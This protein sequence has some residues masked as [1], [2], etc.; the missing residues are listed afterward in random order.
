MTTDD[1]R[2]YSQLEIAD[3]LFIGMMHDNKKDIKVVLPIN[4][5]NSDG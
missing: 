4:Y 3:Q 5:F 1:A 2:E